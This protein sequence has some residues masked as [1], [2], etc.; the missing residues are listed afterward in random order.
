VVDNLPTGLTASSISGTGWT[1]DLPTLTC[2]RSDALASGSAY[3]AISLVVTVAANAGTPLTNTAM[4]SGGGELNTANDTANDSTTIAQ[5]ADLT[6]AKAHTGNF[7]QGQVGANY[8][9]TVTNSGLGAAS[10][11]VTVVDT[12]PASGLTATALSGTGWAC[13]LNTLT[14]TRSDALAPASSYPGITLTVTVANNAPSS[15]TNTAAVSGGGEVNTNNDTA[16]DATTIVQAPDLTIAKS[17]SGNFTQGD[18]GDTFTITVGNAGLGPVVAGNTVTVVDTLPASGLTAT[19]IGG[20][21]WSCTLATLT[22]TRADAL[23]VSA[24]YPAITLTVTVAN[25]APASVTNSATASGG[26]E[27]NTANDTATDPTTI[28]QVPDLTIAKSHTGS[29]TQGQVGALYTITVADAGPGPV[30]AGNTVKVVDTLPASMTATA[31]AGSG[32]TCVLGTL[33]CTRADALANGSSYP[34]ITL[35]VTVAANAPASVTNSATVSGGGEIN[36]AN[37]TA[38]NVTTIAAGPDLTITKAH[39]GNFTVGDTGDTYTITVANAGG[40]SSVGTVT[41]TDTLPASGL[42]AT[43]LAGT[44]WSCTLG[45]LTCT[46]ADALANA[47]SYPAIIL[48]VNVAGNAPASVTNSATVSG[49]GDVNLANNTANDVTTVIQSP[50]PQVV[51][52]SVLWGVQSYNVIG[53]PRNRLPWQINGIRVVFSK[54]IT[55]GD[56]NSLTGLTTTA[57]SGLGTNTL[58]WTITP[59]ALGL[60]PTMLAGSGPDALKDSNG[61]GLAGG[62]GFSQSLKILWGDFN[63]DGVVNSSDAVLVNAARSQPYN[64]FA[65]MNGDGVVDLNDVR[66]VGQRGGTTLP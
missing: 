36:T 46:R 38:N 21:G 34:A 5:V 35:T 23:A 52:F 15:V 57:F 54:P 13:T 31:I 45:T 19:A 24:S 43:A 17:H 65:D 37:D 22:C 26:A 39:S 16:T 4:V 10:G 49:G 20:T 18:V 8:T 25:N 32:W 29:F 64:Q 33:T 61:A 7:T 51:S 63:D 28:V 59:V 41:V 58:T 42:T 48:T 56:V 6:I 47:S 2:T 1:C 14:C 62:A 55:A 66:I 30:I 60:F 40:S 50:P 44:G 12:L 27:I 3:P 9:I 11:T 53:T